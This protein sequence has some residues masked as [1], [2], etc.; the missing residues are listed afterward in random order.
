MYITN[1]Y[2]YT[3]GS[4]NFQVTKYDAITGARKL[5]FNIG[6]PAASAI[7]VTAGS[8]GSVCGYLTPGE[9]MHMT[10]TNAQGTSAHANVV[11]KYMS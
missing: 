9:S 6:Y 5:I 11:I 1:I 2:G 8:D 10:I 4:N 3:A 7:N